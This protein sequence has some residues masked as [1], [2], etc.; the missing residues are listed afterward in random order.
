[1]PSVESQILKESFKLNTR[2]QSTYDPYK[3]SKEGNDSRFVSNSVCLFIR[4]SR[5]NRYIDLNQ[6]RRTLNHEEGHKLHCTAITD[7][8]AGGAAGKE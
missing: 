3:R 6:I 2:S 4:L 5:L 7:I 8:N 1:M